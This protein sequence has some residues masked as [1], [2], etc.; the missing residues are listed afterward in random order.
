MSAVTFVPT[1]ETLLDSAFGLKAY[2]YILYGAQN[3]QWLLVCTR[4]YVDCV[5]CEV[6]TEFLY[7]V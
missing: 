1:A 7:I 5:C 6:G 3:K 4:L 2:S